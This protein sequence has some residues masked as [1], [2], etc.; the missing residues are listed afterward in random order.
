M[1]EECIDY[2]LSYYYNFGID[3][4]IVDMIHYYPDSK[5]LHRECTSQSCNYRTF[6][7]MGSID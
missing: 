7:N 1:C 5:L 3:I 4:Y 2:S 6:I